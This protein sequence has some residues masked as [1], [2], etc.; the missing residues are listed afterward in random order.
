[1]KSKKL[2]L[3]K[4]IRI[5]GPKKRALWSGPGEPIVEV[6]L[7]VLVAPK[8]PQVPRPRVTRF[9]NFDCPHPP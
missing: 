6:I 9:R 7:I 4:K 3:V 1:M 2:K 8:A 5:R